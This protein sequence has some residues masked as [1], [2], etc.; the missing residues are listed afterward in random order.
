M[1]YMAATDRH[2][3]TCQEGGPHLC[4]VGGFGAGLSTCCYGIWGYFPTEHETKREA[5]LI[6]PGNAHE[7]FWTSWY[8]Y[9]PPFE[10]LLELQT[11]EARVGCE[12]LDAPHL[13]PYDTLFAKPDELVDRCIYRLNVCC[14]LFWKEKNGMWALR[15]KEEYLVPNLALVIA[16]K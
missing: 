13:S 5:R 3:K 6:T 2:K 4:S 16:E 14:H 15:S 7:K 1:G 11:R 9:Q 10:T 8:P 12:Q